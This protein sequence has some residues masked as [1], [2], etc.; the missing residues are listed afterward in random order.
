MLDSKED[1]FTSVS[2]VIVDTTPKFGRDHIKLQHVM[3]RPFQ[4]WTTPWEAV[5][6]LPKY[7]LPTSRLADSKEVSLG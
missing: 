7:Y 3:F 1:V 6:V 4:G 2:L 5:V